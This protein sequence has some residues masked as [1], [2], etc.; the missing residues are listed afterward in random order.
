VGGRRWA[1]ASR[2][3]DDEV[4]PY[5]RGLVLEGV[6]HVTVRDDLPDPTVERSTDAVIAVTRTGLCGSDLHPYE[7]RETVRFGV[8][9]GHEAVGKVVALGTDVTGFALDQRV[10]VPFTTSCGTCPPC[11]GG[12]SSRCVAGALFGFG[13]PDDLRTPALH[14]GQA[15]YVRV[16]LAGST[17]VAIPDRVDDA[18]AVLLTDNLPT[19]WAAATRG[20]VRPGSRVVVVGLGSVGLCSLHAARALGAASLLAVDPVETRR[21]SA[22]ALGADMAVDP[23]HAEVAAAD[24]TAGEGA[25]VAIDASGTTAGQ[26]L[27][28]ATLRPGGTLSIIA[29]QTAERFGV[30]PVQAYDRNLTIRA[31]RAPVR[32]LLDELLPRLLTGELTVPTD[33]LLTHPAESLADGPAWY[34][35][36]A[37]REPGLVKAAL[38]P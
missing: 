38:V 32:S 12:L 22:L 8:I 7:G 17:M 36:F 10:L 29:V 13:D 2:D 23:D 19:G 25:D 27:A 11:R 26:A 3:D 30:G 34:R 6:G 28:A 9:P 18:A 24:A 37:A 33:R 16:P 1:V 31:G 15:E 5:V 14:G 35:R 21:A 4:E 20:E